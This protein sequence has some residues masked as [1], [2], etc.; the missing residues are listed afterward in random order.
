[1]LRNNTI[2][3]DTLRTDLPEPRLTP[4]RCAFFASAWMTLLLCTSMVASQAIAMP[5][6]KQTPTNTPRPR[7]PVAAQLNALPSGTS[8]TPPATL[9]PQAPAKP[10]FWLWTAPHWHYPK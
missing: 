3:L 2:P 8:P 9:A 6:P 10:G 5:P 1:M 4:A 7:D